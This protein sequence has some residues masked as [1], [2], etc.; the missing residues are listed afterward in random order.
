MNALWRHVGLGHNSPSQ[1]CWGRRHNLLNHSSSTANSSTE[2]RLKEVFSWLIKKELK[3]IPRRYHLRRRLYSSW[4]ILL[5]SINFSTLFLSSVFHCEYYVSLN[6]PC[7]KSLVHS[8][9][10]LG[11]VRTLRKWSLLGV[12]WLTER[13]VRFRGT[14]FLFLSPWRWGWGHFHLPHA[15]GMKQ[16][17]HCSAIHHSKGRLTNIPTYSL[18]TKEVPPGS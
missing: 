8:V 5:K 15:P 18:K 11:D 6:G 16:S 3:A 2:E 12:L 17:F 7:D 9:V 14:P 10:L 1:R 4:K 13:I